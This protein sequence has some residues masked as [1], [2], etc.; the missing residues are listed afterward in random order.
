MNL[1]I[2]FFNE[3]TMNAR[4]TL[5]KVEKT[6]YFEGSRRFFP[7]ADEASRVKIELIT[8][9]FDESFNAQSGG[10][11]S[12]DDGTA[13][14]FSANSVQLAD[15]ELYQGEVKVAMKWLDPTAVNT[16]NQMPG[17]LQGVNASNQG[18]RFENFWHDGCRIA[19]LFW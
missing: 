19:G 3:E 2:F 12:K 17:D 7:T 13:I 6:G 10:A 9:S 14:Q 1:G 8:Q 16:L 4:G 15:G 11:V 18:S 5:V